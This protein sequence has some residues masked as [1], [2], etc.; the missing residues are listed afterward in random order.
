MYS[1]NLLTLENVSFDQGRGKILRDISFSV[2]QGENIVIFGPEE[3]GVHI[4]CPV[5]SGMEPG[6]NGEIYYKGKPIKNFDYIE[7]HQYRKDLGYLQNNY[8]LINNMTVEENISLPLKYH[9]N[10]STGEIRELVDH[11]INELHLNHCRNYR[12]VNLLRSEILKTAFIRSISLEPDILLVENAL[13]GQCQIN[14]QTFLDVLKKECLDKGT[15]A[16]IITYYPRLFA[17]Y[18]DRFA[19]LYNG[20]IVF[21]GNREDL[22]S[23]GNKYLQQFLNSSIEGPMEIL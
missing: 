21:T 19:M 14:V 17:D 4:L 8:G 10:L 9:S 13:E 2:K 1:Q 11:Y 7:N 18:S 6:F 3:S 23:S 5:I 15:S 20:E 16:I 22:F 12:P